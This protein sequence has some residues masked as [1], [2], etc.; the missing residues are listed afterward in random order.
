MSARW[1]VDH[2]VSLEDAASRF[3]MKSGKN[4]PAL[5][6]Y[7]GCIKTEFDGVS[8]ESLCIEESPEGSDSSE[9]TIQMQ[10]D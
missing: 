3:G 1:S 2:K 7:V 4:G 6:R 9:V 10:R 5:G 8:G